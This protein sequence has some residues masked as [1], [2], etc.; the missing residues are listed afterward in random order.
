MGISPLVVGL[1]IVSFGT[2]S[3]ELAV[4]LG[5]AWKGQPD[6]VIGNAIGS[7]IFN[8]LFILGVSALITPLVVH[9]RLVRLDVPIMIGTCL[10]LWAMSLDGVLGRIDA[11]LLLTGIIAYT[12]WAVHLSRR[13]SKEIAA[14]YADELKPLVKKKPKL[15]VQLGWIV[16]G[17]VLCVLGAQW[18]VEGAVK[19]ARSLG[20]DELIIGLTIV[21]AGTSLPELATSIMAAV[22]GHRDI[23]VGNVVGSNI[24]NILAIL[25]LT[26]LFSPATVNIP[27]TVL[28][29][30]LP[31]MTAV[32]LAC[33]PVV[34]SHH[35]ISRWEGALF[36][37]LY[38]AYV[39]YLVLASRNSDGAQPFGNIMIWAV[40]PLAC[41]GLA[42]GFVRSVAVSRK[43]QANEDL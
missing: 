5:A 17:L 31:V 28:Q 14:E 18:M 13:E 6:L 29:F 36:L 20:F 24:F 41:L 16:L 34:F 23:A 15:M 8:V 7:N 30:G 42:V 9:Q 22:R 19:V 27:E 12:G 4:S 33:L 40:I 11:A 38:I 35:R 10:A 21:A 37:G 1:T 25:G 3:P 43:N 39:V 26:G 32:S 2:S